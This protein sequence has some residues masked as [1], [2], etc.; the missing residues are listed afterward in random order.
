MKI[1]P[2]SGKSQVM[3]LLQTTAAGASRQQRVAALSETTEAHRDSIQLLRCNP[4]L[5]KPRDPKMI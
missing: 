5:Q 2:L 3:R 4:G 1:L